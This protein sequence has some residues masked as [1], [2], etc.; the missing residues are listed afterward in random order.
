MWP[1]STALPT[2]S[3]PAQL[4][5]RAC[6]A[7]VHAAN[8]GQHC[9]V[10]IAARHHVAQVV[11]ELVGAGDQVLPAFQRLVHDHRQ[12]VAQ[13]LVI[14]LQ[15]HRA[16]KSRRP[17]EILLQAPR[18]AWCGAPLRR[19][20][21]AVSFRSPGD[22][23]AETPPRRAM[24]LLRRRLSSRSA[25]QRHVGH[26]LDVARRRNL[27]ELRHVRDRRAARRR[28]Q[29]R[30]A[31]SCG[32]HLVQRAQAAKWLSPDSPHTRT[33]GS[34]RSGPRPHRCRP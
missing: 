9:P 21:R 7:L 3:L 30:R 1:T 18:P 14:V 2:T 16:Q 34:L 10:K 4:S 26:A 24:C 29:L 19:W 6:L 25:L 31:V 17:L 27:E 28:H 11:V 23:R 20:L 15:S 8:V 12:S 22:R 5:L 33:P 32:N 13:R